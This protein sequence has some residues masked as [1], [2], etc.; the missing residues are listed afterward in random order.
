MRP[1]NRTRGISDGVHHLESLAPPRP[2]AHEG[3]VFLRAAGWRSGPPRF[4]GASCRTA[5]SSCGANPLRRAPWCRRSTTAPEADVPPRI[6]RAVFAAR[7][8]GTVALDTGVLWLRALW[9]AC[10]R[11]T[12]TTPVSAPRRTRIVFI[13]PDS[14]GDLV[15][16]SASWPALRRLYPTH[17]YSWTWIGQPP[18]PPLMHLCGQFDET[19]TVEAQRFQAAS[20]LG[21]RLRP[22]WRVS[23]VSADLVIHP[24]RSRVFLIGDTLA[25]AVAAPEKIASAGDAANS[26]PGSFASGTVSTRESCRGAGTVTNWRS[27]PIS[28][29]SWA[30]RSQPR[31]SRGCDLWRSGPQDRP[32]PSPTSWFCPVRVPPFVSGDMTDSF[33]RPCTCSSSTDGCA[34][35]PGH[36]PIAHVIRARCL[37]RRCVRWT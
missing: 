13:R 28:S 2:P 8:L 33:A 31:W 19:L 20:G 34:C 6:Q 18:Q 17:S 27:P 15:L 25:R 5:T 3:P 23:G 36:L 22:L 10:R 21:Y 32:S 11:L 26:P 29:H 35:G 14:L 4:S 16:W 9:N 37:H 12:G 7:T 1:L 30:F 24:V